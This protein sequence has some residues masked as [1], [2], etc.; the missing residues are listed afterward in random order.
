MKYKRILS[1]MLLFLI[2]FSYC[3]SAK[4]L[5]EPSALFMGEVEE[6]LKSEK[7]NE[8][9]IKVKGYIK[10]CEVYYEELVGIIINGETIVIP[11]D[12]TVKEGEQPKLEKV[13]ICT[14]KIQKGDIV[15]LLLSEAMTKSIPP[16]SVVKAIQVSKYN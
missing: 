13:D 6:I 2:I 12:C 11:K 4:E 1:I 15:F 9:K 3:P 16:Q 5:N 7:D 8:L 10:G 14:L